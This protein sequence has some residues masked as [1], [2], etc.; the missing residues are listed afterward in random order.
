MGWRQE[1]FNEVSWETIHYTLE[2]KLNMCGIWLSKQL[3]VCGAMGHNMVRLVKTLEGHL[4]NKCPNYG[5]V[6]IANHLC[7]CQCPYKHRTMLLEE[8]ME[9]LEGLF[10]QDGRMHSELA[11]W[12]PTNILCR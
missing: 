9:A 7:R 6:E 2:S 8:G 4:D 11:Y 1:R 5:H 3:S 12:I 10:H